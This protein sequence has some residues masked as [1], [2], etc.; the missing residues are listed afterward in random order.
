MSNK[1]SHSL[2]HEMLYSYFSFVFV[3]VLI[4]VSVFSLITDNL[5]VNM[6]IQSEINT[7]EK[8]CDNLSYAFQQDIAL[9]YTLASNE[10]IIY[11]TRKFNDAS[12]MEQ[13]DYDLTL[14][15]IFES[16]SGYS[17]GIRKIRIFFPENITK[18]TAGYHSVCY[19]SI[20]NSPEWLRFFQPDS[21]AIS[22]E[23][24][25]KSITSHFEP[26]KN[27]IAVIVP[28]MQAQKTIAFLCMDIDKE[29]LFNAY[30]DTDL[31]TVFNNKGTAIYN[32]SKIALNN[33]LISDI[34]KTSHQTHGILRTSGNKLLYFSTNYTS[35]GF[36]IVQYVPYNSLTA[37]RPIIITVFFFILILLFIITLVFV[38]QKAE[39]FTKPLSDLSDSMHY[40][41]PAPKYEILPTEIA[42][43]YNTYNDLLSENAKMLENANESSKKQHRLEIK[44]LLAQISPHFLYNTLNTIVWKA[45]KAGNFE[46]C[47]VIG[48]LAKLCNLNYTS[49]DDFVPLETELRHI[50]L[51]LQIQQEAFG[52]P[53][54]YTIS[55]SDDIARLIVP[56]FILQ[57]IVENSILHGFTQLVMDKEITVSAEADRELII[58]ISDNGIGITKDNLVKLN[59]NNYKSE[60]YGIRNINQRIKMLCGDSYGII[61]ESNGHSYT[62]AVITLPVIYDKSETDK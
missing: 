29:M 57:P 36:K 3:L 8:A 5:I 24:T 19:L 43:L 1:T 46:I 30:L 32:T 15:G 6:N 39:R 35:H 25:C 59:S 50:E 11:N 4:I 28:I 58:I 22:L 10:Q 26:D 31:Y 40:S 23:Y 38:L 41:L 44:A 17:S 52:Q 53:F 16:Y 9:A 12:F 54:N 60:K 21:A 62:K 47:S 49:T 56:R 13:V 51:Y 7:V 33:D 27:L 14:T 37:H 42:I 2:Y 61:F 48:K 45:T 34:T 20:Y 18:S 55:V